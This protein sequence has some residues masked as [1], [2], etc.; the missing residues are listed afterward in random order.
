[1]LEAKKNRLNYGELLSPPPGYELDYALGTSYSLDLKTLLALPIA[2][3]YART[4]DGDFSQDRFDVLDAIRKCNERV[5][6]FCQRGKVQATEAKGY[7]KLLAFIDSSVVEVTPS[8]YNASFH[9]K[10]WILRFI[11]DDA[12]FYRTIVLSRNLTFDRSWDMAYYTDSKVGKKSN[13]E[14]Q[15]LA[16]YLQYFAEDMDTQLPVNFLVDYSKIVIE[17]SDDFE[18]PQIFPILG[19]NK[20]IE[21]YPNPLETET[22][23]RLLIL[24][25]FV[26]KTTL[27]RFI[28]TTSSKPYLVARQDQLD[29]IY[30]KDKTFL[31]DN[32]DCYTIS[33]VIVDGEQTLDSDG[34]SNITQDLHAKLFVGQSGK[35]TNWYM[36]SANCSE[37]A[38]TRN[39]ELMVKLK[40]ISRST[41]FNS[42]KEQ[43]LGEENGI[44]IPY[45]GKEYDIE[46]L[47]T[48]EEA[49]RKVTHNL[50]SQI[51]NGVFSELNEDQRCSL[52]IS[53]NAEERLHIDEDWS[54]KVRMM[55]Q[56][57][58]YDFL[59]TTSTVQ[60]DT[61]AIEKVSP[62]IVL[63][64][65]YKEQ[66]VSNLAVKMDAVLPTN[67]EDTIFKNLINSKAKFFTYIRFLLSPNDF[68]EG[69]NI[70]EY[71]VSD[72]AEGSANLRSALAFDS[73][74]YEY[75]MLA[76]SRSP[77][78]LTEI[79][80]VLERVKKMDEEIVKD[81]LPI[82]DVFKGFCK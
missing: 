77:K 70:E 1:M 74:I 32:F 65:Y 4:T 16:D 52:T 53:I 76:A 72:K 37:P 44:F 3:F 43:L 46:D 55:H 41:E 20:Q 81:F 71:G 7:N 30:Q 28:K 11:K 75:L 29:A 12:I 64:I 60:I 67:R 10:L 33:D 79:D 56:A 25:P 51:Y 62:F 35:E 57:Q 9:P 13:K 58:E 69:L 23:D 54:V 82:W 68:S 36:G 34:M 61:I 40:S 45:V 31:K 26:Q 6:V 73:P 27:E 19:F 2:M 18:M 17:D 50:I 63:N 38:F 21:K 39:A 14:A 66:Y 48:D 5:T 59:P 8:Q 24:S 80:K 47:A 42:I 49:L 22:F 15:K 78:K